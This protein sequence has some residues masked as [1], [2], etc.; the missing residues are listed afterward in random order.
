[1]PIAI[2]LCKPIAEIPRK[3]VFGD[4]ALGNFFF[5]GDRIG[6]IDFE[7][8]GMG[9][10]FLDTLLVRYHLE[11]I[12]SRLLYKNCS[13]LLEILA[14][15]N[16]FPAY[17]LIYRLGFALSHTLFLEKAR[18]AQPSWKKIMTMQE[19]KQ[20][21]LEVFNIYQAACREGVIEPQ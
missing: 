19:R 9:P 6:R 13:Q 10:P 11:L 2:Q 17:Q 1:L 14:V 3:L 5:D 21:C 8:M 15:S 20:V 18:S 16:L 7:D 12:N 4:V